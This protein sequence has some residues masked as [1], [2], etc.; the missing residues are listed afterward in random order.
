MAQVGFMTFYLPP[1]P[2]FVRVQQGP[3]LVSVGVLCKTAHVC[4]L[5]TRMREKF[6]FLVFLVWLGTFPRKS[7]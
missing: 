4:L 5:T 1:S 3:W 2:K 6:V 7:K